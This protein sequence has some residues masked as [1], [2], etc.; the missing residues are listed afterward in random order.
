MLASTQIMYRN[1]Y[2]SI[3]NVDYLVVDTVI[4]KII[5]FLNDSYD[6]LEVF[7]KYKQ[8]SEALLLKG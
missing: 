3:D 6:S 2:R 4:T 8:L 1:N 5:T 7:V